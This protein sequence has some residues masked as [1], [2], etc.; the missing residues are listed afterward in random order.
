MSFFIQF[1]LDDQTTTIMEFRINLENEMFRIQTQSCL[2]KLN[3]Q[4]F[5]PNTECVLAIQLYSRIDA[6]R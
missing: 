6:E 3:R 5:T 4:M 1:L 2:M